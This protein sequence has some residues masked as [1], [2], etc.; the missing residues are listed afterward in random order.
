MPECAQHYPR[1]S[2][3]GKII[4]KQITTKVSVASGANL[5]GL[6]VTAEKSSSPRSRLP[7]DGMGSLTPRPSM[8]RVASVKMNTGMETQNCAS[9]AG[10]RLGKIWRKI[11]RIG[12]QPVDL[13]R[14]RKSEFRIFRVAA[15]ITRRED[16]QPNKPRIRN[17]A[18]TETSGA[19]FKGS[20]ARSAINTKSSGEAIDK[21]AMARIARSHHPPRNPAAPPRAPA[22]R[23][24][25][26]A[27]AGARSS[28]TRVP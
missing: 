3:G 13:A 12:P 8:L 23:V 1:S 20:M 7:H 24:E 17:V 16:G 6:D 15:Q 27:A 9:N 19:R 21:S 10:R 11:M 26:K 22:I 4:W 5:P 25:S 18:I 28:D 2:W 14:S